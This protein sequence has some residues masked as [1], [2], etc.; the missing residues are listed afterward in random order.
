MKEVVDLIFTNFW[1]WL[2]F[3]IYILAF[4]GGLKK[5]FA[6]VFDEVDRWRKKG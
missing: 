1:T 3:L 5:I 4:T 2:G 6:F